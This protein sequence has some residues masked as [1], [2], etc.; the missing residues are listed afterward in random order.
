MGLAELA[1]YRELTSFDLKVTSAISNPNIAGSSRTQLSWIWTTHQGVEPTDNHLTECEFPV[2]SMA[3]L[4]RWKEEVI[5]TQNEMHWAT[6]YFTLRH[7]QW[8]TWQSSHPELTDGHQAYAEHQ[9]AMWSE[10]GQQARHVFKETW[11]DF[12]S[13]PSVFSSL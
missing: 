4:H 2:F 10:I 1:V 6:N 5:L 9:K 7:S 3:Q 11:A 12:D 13:D 8:T